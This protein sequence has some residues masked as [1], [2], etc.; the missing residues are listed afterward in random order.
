MGFLLSKIKEVG[1]LN[2]YNDTSA[3]SN[4]TDSLRL[5]EG[6]L[7]CPL[8][9]PEEGKA[10]GQAVESSRRFSGRAAFRHDSFA[11]VLD[12]VGW[13][14]LE[15]R[16]MFFCARSIHVG[17]SFNMSIGNRQRKTMGRGSSDVRVVLSS[18]A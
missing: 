13:T 11:G 14:L 2:L 12:A 8:T 15:R 4:K 16:W 7:P 1:Y 10:K 18:R 6:L 9:L 3:G 17:L 5:S